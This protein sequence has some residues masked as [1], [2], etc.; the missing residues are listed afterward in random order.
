MMGILAIKS[1]LCVF[2]IVQI[3]KY[4]CIYSSTYVHGHLRNYP[5]W[6]VKMINTYMDKR[7]IIV[8][9]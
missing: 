1:P 5:A 2:V 9:G 8:R 7:N 3:M 6:L 4:I